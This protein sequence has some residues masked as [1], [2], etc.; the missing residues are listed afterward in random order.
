[1]FKKKTVSICEALNF[2][3]PL[4][5]I[6]GGRHWASAR[7]GQS[8]TVGSTLVL[9]KRRGIWKTEN[10]R[11]TFFLNILYHVYCSSNHTY[12][13]RTHHLLLSIKKKGKSGF[14]KNVMAYSMLL[15]FRSLCP[16][17]GWSVIVFLSEHHRFDVLSTSG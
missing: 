1:M 11:N 14:L 10:M 16:S 9:T 4:L 2:C 12:S 8:I 5:T 17:V 15:C 3:H 13:W 7:A 6:T